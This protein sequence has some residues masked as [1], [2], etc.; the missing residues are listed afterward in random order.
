MMMKTPPL[1][2]DKTEVMVIHLIQNYH[3]FEVSYISYF[4]SWFILLQRI[5]YILYI[6]V[7][8]KY[9]Y[10]CYKKYSYLCL[11]T[12]V[13]RQIS[14]LLKVDLKATKTGKTSFHLRRQKTRFA[15]DIA[16]PIIEP[17]QHR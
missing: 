5:I 11:K 3:P 12:N 1:I 14:V 4:F 9:L 15:F 10:F 2:F 16:I 7:Y 6:I 8:Y 13:Y 17:L